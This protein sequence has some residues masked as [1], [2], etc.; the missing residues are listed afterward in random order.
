MGGGGPTMT[1]EEEGNC[2][3]GGFWRGGKELRE[4]VCCCLNLL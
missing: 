2:K 3:G 4:A 1:R